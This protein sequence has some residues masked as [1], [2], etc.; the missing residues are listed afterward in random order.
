M[1]A[2]QAL[3]QVAKCIKI[4]PRTSV[5][6]HRSGETSPAT[7][8]ILWLLDASRIHAVGRSGLSALSLVRQMVRK[9]FVNGIGA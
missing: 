9:E 4:E 2:Q 6:V 5:D 1:Q 7:P 8:T 3:M